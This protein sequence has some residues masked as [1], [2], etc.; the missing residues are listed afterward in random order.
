MSACEDGLCVCVHLYAHTFTHLCLALLCVPSLS[1]V[2][3]SPCDGC[4]EIRDC[5]VVF[6]TAVFWG[7]S[8]PGAVDLE[9][10]VM[11]W[12]WRNHK[13]Q[14]ANDVMDQW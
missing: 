1:A 7:N 8:Q 6:D 5:A 9:D 3:I 2:I 12:K 14:G 11:P 4:C 10:L 13:Y